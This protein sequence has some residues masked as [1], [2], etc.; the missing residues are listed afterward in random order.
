[1]TITKATTVA[2]DVHWNEINISVGTYAEMITPPQANISYIADGVVVVDSESTRTNGFKLTKSG[3]T[4]DG[5][6]ISDSVQ[7]SIRGDAATNATIL[8][9]IINK[10]VVLDNASHFPIFRNITGTAGAAIDVENSTDAIIEDCDISTIALRG[11]YLYASPRSVVRNGYCNGATG[12]S[13]YGGESEAS[14]DDSAWIRCWVIGSF[15]NGLISKTSLRVRFEGCVI[16][17]AINSRGILFKH[18]RNGL[19]NN[20]VIYGC[21]DGI[22]LEDNGGTNYST[23]NTVKNT[24]IMN[25]HRG[26][27]VKAGSET[28]FTSDYNCFYGNTHIGEWNGTEYDTLAAWQAATGQDAHSVELD[29]NYA[30]VTYPNGFQLPVGNGLLTAGEGGIAIGIDGS[31][32]DG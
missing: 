15:L 14:A 27:V 19:V 9:C 4:I 26:I 11:F 31:T 18:G 5:F 12:A 23:G 17:G 13:A 25:N 22:Y 6:T 21:N 20:C 1:M 3:I 8:N 29:P 24:I 10:A 2:T 30:D 16:S 7:E 32:W 28:G